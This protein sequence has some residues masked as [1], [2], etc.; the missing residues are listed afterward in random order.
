MARPRIVVTLSSPERAADPAVAE[1][2]NQRYL[3]A[4]ERH[5]AT[6]VPVDER[7]PAPALD[8][9]LATMD[10]LLITGGADLDPALYGEAP[11]GSK[12]PDPGRDALDASAF[13]AATDRGIPILGVCR[14]LQ[15][16]N[17]F[18]GGRLVQHVNHHESPPYPARA[19]DAT[20][21]LLRLTPGT[22]LAGILGS[23]ETL[24]VNSFH[25]QAV[26]PDG[27]ANGLRAAGIAPH[28]GGD[29]VEALEAVDANRWLVA[30]QCHPERVESTPGE[31]D[32]LWAAFVA[33]AAGKMGSAPRPA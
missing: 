12:P 23:A 20:R 31:M 19:A 5:G 16:V 6:A 9:A 29:L 8:E 7:V 22:R 25:H 28:D 4:L 24:E 33:A 18:S 27:L 13:A 15:A 21:H 14:G 26:A 3:A 17:V 11:D 2:K 1:E 10:G 30:V 32:A